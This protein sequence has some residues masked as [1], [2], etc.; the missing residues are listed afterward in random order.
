[1]II[2]SHKNIEIHHTHGS[3]HWDEQ[4]MYRLGQIR[5]PRESG[6]IG[7]TEMPFGAFDY[8]IPQVSSIN[9]SI[10]FSFRSEVI[11]K[12]PSKMPP[13]TA[14]GGISRERFLRGLRHFTG[15]SGTIGPTRL[16]DMTSL[17]VSGLLQTVTK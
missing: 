12:K 7:S 8:E 13:S 14:S 5:S 10:F 4:R 11:L 17:A 6:T 16:L 1:M 2:I 9:Q 3:A 15:L